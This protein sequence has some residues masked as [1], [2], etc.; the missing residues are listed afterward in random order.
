MI[1]AI[2]LR[3]AWLLRFSKM[4]DTIAKFLTHFKQIFEKFGYL[5]SRIVI[6]SKPF[7]HNLSLKNENERFPGMSPSFPVLFSFEVGFI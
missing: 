4:A 6:I 5:K 7:M 2:W 3:A 1:S